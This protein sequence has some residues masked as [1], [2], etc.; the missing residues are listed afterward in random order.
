M[1]ALSK[2]V[3]Q[4]IK[5]GEMVGYITYGAGEYVRKVSF[6]ACKKTLLAHAIDDVLPVTETTLPIMITYE[7]VVTA[8]DDEEE[9]SD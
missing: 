2:R 8:D 1:R 3:K 7:E 5:N 4:K 9:L 6:A